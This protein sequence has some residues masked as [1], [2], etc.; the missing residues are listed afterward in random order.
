[1]RHG[2]AV[3]PATSG[4]AYSPSS[5]SST[6]GGQR[7]KILSRS[8]AIGGTA[9]VVNMRRA[10]SGGGSARAADTSSSCGKPAATPVAPQR[11]TQSSRSAPVATRTS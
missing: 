6:W 8:R 1:M 5:C 7:S 4:A 3:S 10:R 11:C 2:R 9:S